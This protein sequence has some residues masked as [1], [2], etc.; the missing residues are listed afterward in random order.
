MRRVTVTSHL[1]VLTTVALRRLL[2]LLANE[3]CTSR[4]WWK[5]A[6]PAFKGMADPRYE[7]FPEKKRSRQK[8]RI[9]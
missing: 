1:T 8:K 5:E 3:P 9:A 6:Y 4:G 7:I 2:L